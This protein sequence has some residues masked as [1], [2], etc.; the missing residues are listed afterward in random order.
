MKWSPDEFGWVGACGRDRIAAAPAPM[1]SK[2]FYV[3][4]SVGAKITYFYIIF[5]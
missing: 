2:T 1:E 5:L 3:K 4:R